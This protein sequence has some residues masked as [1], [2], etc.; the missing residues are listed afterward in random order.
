MRNFLQGKGEGKGGTAGGE[1]VRDRFV[2]VETQ[3]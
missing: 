1:V 2:H 3:Y